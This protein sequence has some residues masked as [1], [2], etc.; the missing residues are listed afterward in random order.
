M[1]AKAAP[2]TTSAAYLQ[3][4]PA[5]SAAIAGRKT[6]WPVEEAAEKR[7]VTRPRRDS[8]HRLATTDPRTRAIAPAPNPTNPPQRTHNCQGEVITV[9]SP[10]PI[11]TSS[12][13]ATMTRRRPRRS[14]RAAANGAVRP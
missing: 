13:A 14:M 12:S 7:P 5:A 1:I 2:A 10:L 11:P 6:S 8:N 4:G 3:P 9:V